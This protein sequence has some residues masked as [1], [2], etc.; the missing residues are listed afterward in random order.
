MPSRE[1]LTHSPEETI[2][3]GRELAAQLR[4]PVLL[5]LDGELGSGKTTLSKGI[6][7][8]LG[9]AREEDVTSPT[10]TLV[11][12]F[13]NGVKVFH[14]DLYRVADRHDLETLGLEDLFAEPA[15]VLVEWP[16]RLALRTDWPIVQVRLE[17]V[18]GDIR[19]VR[20]SDPAGVLSGL[21]PQS[22]EPAPK[23]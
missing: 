4:P 23:P 9:V 2:A 12:A 8:G 3:L 15:I 16:D 21:S 1:F 7:S 6:I 22:S 11:H 13:R 17:H 19:R 20:I 18:E 14:V 5:C 10:F